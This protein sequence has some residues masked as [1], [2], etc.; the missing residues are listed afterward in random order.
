MCYFIIF[1]IF[2]FVNFVLT[3]IFT[4]FAPKV[5]KLLY[6]GIKRIKILCS[7]IDFT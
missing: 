5:V 3:S 6:Y 2:C 1:S 7:A 4:T